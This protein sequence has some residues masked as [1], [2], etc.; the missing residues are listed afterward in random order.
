[1]DSFSKELQEEKYNS[2][3]QDDS[4]YFSSE[5]I[6]E[7]VKKFKPKKT[8]IETRDRIFDENKRLQADLLFFKTKNSSLIKENTELKRQKEVESKILSEKLKHYGGSIVK[9]NAFL[10]RLRRLT[11]SLNSSINNINETPNTKNANEKAELALSIFIAFY[12]LRT[13]SF[14]LNSIRNFLRAGKRAK[15]LVL[16]DAKNCNKKI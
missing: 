6:K 2:D 5:D 16:N 12:S 13:A 15:K 4:Q 3:L 7:E 14:L 11:D 9:I 1:M 8:E 10:K